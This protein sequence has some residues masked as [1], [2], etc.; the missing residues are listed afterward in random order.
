MYTNLG[1]E[2]NYI[3][4]HAVIELEMFCEKCSHLSNDQSMLREEHSVIE[5]SPSRVSLSGY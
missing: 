1:R 4:E 3:K 5:M 2:T